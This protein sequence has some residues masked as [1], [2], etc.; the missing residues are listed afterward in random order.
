MENSLPDRTE[1]LSVQLRNSKE[2]V[3]KTIKLTFIIM[4]AA[5]T[6]ACN[7]KGDDSAKSQ[8]LVTLLD[9]SKNKSDARYAPCTA[10]VAIMN[11]C[12]SVNNGFGN[13]EMC[14]ANV[15]AGIK[16]V[17]TSAT[18]E[19]L[20]KCVSAAV[21][22]SFCNFPQNRVTSPKAAYDSFFKACD[23]DGVIL[24]YNK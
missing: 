5:L 24:F 12:V 7:S 1:S 10:A 20:I 19:T 4:L 15:W 2:T 16:T 13:A 3:M 11:Q 9:A 14:T 8:I 23:T 6:A 21:N 22:T 17:P 18:Y